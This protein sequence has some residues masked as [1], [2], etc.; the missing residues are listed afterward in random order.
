[1]KYILLCFMPLL[2]LCACSHEKALYVHTTNKVFSPGIKDS[3]DIKVDGSL[4]FQSLDKEGK[5]SP[6]SFFADVAWSP[7]NHLSIF[8]SYRG[9][10]SKGVTHERFYGGVLNSRNLEYQTFD[11]NG[12]AGDMGIG[13]YCRTGEIGKFEVYGGF[14]V[15][16]LFNSSND[17]DPGYYRLNYYRYFTQVG[18]GYDYDILSFMTGFRLSMEQLTSFVDGGNIAQGYGTGAIP[19]LLNITRSYVDPYMELQIGGRHVKFTMQLGYD[20]SVYTHPAGILYRPSAGYITMGVVYQRNP[21][22]RKK[23]HP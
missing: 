10:N 1:M 23:Q 18:Y 7:V 9:V 6:V 17:I 4:K 16:N 5:G 8:G 19:D 3:G 15:G 2:L 20:I 12:Y 22:V 11:L 13:Y 14:G 21:A